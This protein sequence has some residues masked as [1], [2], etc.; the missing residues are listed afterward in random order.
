MALCIHP[1]GKRTEFKWSIEEANRQLGGWFCSI[2]GQ[3]RTGY[4]CLVHDEGAILN[5]PLPRNAL[6]ERLTG[7]PEIYGPIVVASFEESGEKDLIDVIRKDDRHLFE[8]RLV[9]ISDFS[10]L[11]QGAKS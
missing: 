8:A 1:D 3:M 6:A 7:Y 2:P 5:P 11:Q 9:A 10:S 4:L